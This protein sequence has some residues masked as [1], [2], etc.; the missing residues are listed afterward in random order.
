MKDLINNGIANYGIKFSIA[1][2]HSKIQFFLDK[3]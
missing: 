3:K 2:I 1:H